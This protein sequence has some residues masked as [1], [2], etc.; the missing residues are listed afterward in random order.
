DDYMLYVFAKAV[1]LSGPSKP[2][3]R[4][5]L[6][7][8]LKCCQWGKKIGTYGKFVIPHEDAHKE[9]EELMQLKKEG[10]FVVLKK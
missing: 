2:M 7:I 1:E 5:I 10:K 9:I 6:R 3:T 8:V 4:L